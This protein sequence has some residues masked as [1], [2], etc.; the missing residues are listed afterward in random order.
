M[1]MAVP[2][3][4]SLALGED[5]TSVAY[6]GQKNIDQFY[7]NDLYTNTTQAEEETRFVFTII[8]SRIYNDQ[9]INTFLPT[10]L[11]W[12]LAYSTLLIKI[13][14]FQD[15]FMGTVT[16]LLVLAALL[17]SISMSLPRTSYFK[18]IDIWFL[19]YLANI[20]GI[21]IYHIILDMD[22][23]AMGE[24]N[25]STRVFAIDVSSLEEEGNEKSKLGKAFSKLFSLDKKSPYEKNKYTKKSVNKMA[26][27]LFPI[28]VFCFNVIYF[29]LTT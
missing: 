6:N 27:I 24:S 16:A 22:V 5:D 9:M 4:N 20:F 18:Y 29:L 1:K 8:M 15:R 25:A 19:W 28:V 7:I 21:I 11:L 3:N 13:E 10:F 17:S 14:D 23:I 2:K 26:S 12:L